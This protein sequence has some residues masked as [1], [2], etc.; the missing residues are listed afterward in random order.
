MEMMTPQRAEDLA[1][2]LRDAAGSGK[3]V[4]LLGNGT[5]QRAGGP[6]AAGLRI[7]TAGL[8]QVL[9][10]EPKDLTVSVGA[11]MLYSDFTAMLAKDGYMVP[12]DPP[13]AKRATLGGVIASNSSG[14]RRRLYGTARDVVIGMKFATTEGKLV[15]TGGMVVK[16]VAG[17]DM[18]KLLIGSLGT[19]AAIAVVNFKLMPLPEA[20]RSFLFSYANPADAFA[21]RDRILQ[22]VMQPAAVD[23]LNPQASRELN[24]QG[25]LLA[26]A[27]A[28]NARVLER[29]KQELA[30]SELLDGEAERSF[31]ETVQEYPSRFL[32]SQPDGA[33]VR[34]SFTL[35][36]LKGAIGK[37]PGAVIARS[38]NGVCYSYHPESA[39]AKRALEMGS[40]VMEYGPASRTAG[41][42]MWP[43]V[44]SGFPTMQRIKAM[45]D[46]KNVLN[47]G[48]LYGRI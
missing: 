22:S 30:G 43:R 33:I 46:P 16:N 48:R 39:Q 4:E 26:I 19:L 25:W 15:Q 36:D 3:I 21:Q 5:K 8:A 37:L 12:L 7:S 14:P 11:G 18:G 34:H 10:Y 41:V 24:R 23:L 45:F 13:F 1:D 17:L 31:W 6:I 35:R 9:Q 32:E 44:D 27:T 20:T 38:A 28:G 42:T 2:C 29:Y 47:P 40:T